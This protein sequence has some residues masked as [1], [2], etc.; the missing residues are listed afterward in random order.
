MAGGAQFSSTGRSTTSARHP[1]DARLLAGPRRRRCWRSCARWPTR[2]PWPTVRPAPDGRQLPETGVAPVGSVAIN[3]VDASTTATLPDGVAIVV[4]GPL[5]VPVSQVLSSAATAGS[6]GGPVRPP[7][8][9]RW[10]STWCGARSS[11]SSPAT[12]TPPA[13]SPSVRAAAHLPTA[14]STPQPHPRP[15]ARPSW[16]WSPAPSAPPSVAPPPTRTRRRR[17][18]R[19]LPGRSSSAATG[20]TVRLGAATLIFVPGALAGADL[21]PGPPHAADRHRAAATSDVFD[22]LAFDAATGARGHHLRRGTDPLRRGRQRRRH[23]GASGTST[24][25]T[26]PQRIASTSSTAWSARRCRTSAPT[27]SASTGAD[28]LAAIATLLAEHPTGDR[29][30]PVQVTFTGTRSLGRRAHDQRRRP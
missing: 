1:A 2:S 18:S 29:D 7:T 16:T 6:A 28:L 12:C 11:P 3:A 5:G 22:L 4:G 8:A 26:G 10:R 27:S 24:R 30:R 9:C 25:S 19:R 14:A 23:L 13:T 20:G 21:D 15:A 17:R